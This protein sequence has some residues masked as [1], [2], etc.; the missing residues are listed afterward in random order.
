MGSYWNRYYI[1]AKP[2]YISFLSAVI[3]IL[4]IGV[5][6]KW[7]AIASEQEMIVIPEGPFKMGSSEKDIMWAAKHF[8]SESLDW[9]RDETPLHQ[10]ALPTFKIDKYPVTVRDY[11]KYMEVTG[12]PAPRE[13]DNASFNHPLQPVVGLAWATAREYCHWAK[14]RLPTEAEWEKAARGTDA[15]YYPWGNEPDIFNANIRGKGDI[16]RYSNQVGKFPEGASPYGVMDLS[17]N[18]WEWTENWYQ[19]HPGN[20]YENDLYGEQF[21]V[22]K[23]GSWNSNMD[24]AR[25]AVRGKALPDQKKNYIGFRCVASN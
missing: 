19:P 20:Q 1:F 11:A 24:L 7:N 14:K 4:S 17:G 5:F 13:H 23:G 8:H 15:R 3:F 6:G 21:K 18:V 2:V 22:I 9:Y 16:Y 25:G 10:V 12:K